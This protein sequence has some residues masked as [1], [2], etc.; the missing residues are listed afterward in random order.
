MPPRREPGRTALLLSTFDGERFLPEQLTSL[1][2][3]TDQAWTLRWRDDGSSD[4]S[5]EIVEDFAA[6]LPTGRCIREPA[7][8]GRVGACRS[9]LSLLAAEM[10]GDEAPD[11][12]AFADQDD[13]WLP[14]KLARGRSSLEQVPHAIPAL[15]CARQILVDANLQ[16]IGNSLRINGMVGF[17]MALTQNV[18]TGCTVMLNAAAARLIAATQPPPGTVHDWWSYLMVSAAGGLLLVDDQPVVL[19]RQHAGNMVGA[20]SS[21]GKRALAALKRGPGIFMAVFRQHL[22]AL[23]AHEKSLSPEARADLSAIQAALAG[24]TLRRLSVLSCSGLRRQTLL[25]TLLF[26]VWFLVS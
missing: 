24:G 10:A 23:A 26:H 5:I 4:R 20:P 12:I 16:L 7:P 18:A 25:E 6:K 11:L 17:P 19:Y 1:L 22:A 9:F 13:V 2:A 21:V 15:Y 8:V 14:E 3:Q